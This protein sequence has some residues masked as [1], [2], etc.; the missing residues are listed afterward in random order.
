MAELGNQARLSALVARLRTVAENEGAPQ[1]EVPQGLPH[2]SLATP[3]ARS[4]SQDVAI[5]T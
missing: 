5:R 3:G 2:M 4:M 1:G